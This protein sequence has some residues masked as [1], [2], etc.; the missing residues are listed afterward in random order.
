MDIVSI[1]NNNMLLTENETKIK[2]IQLSHDFP[3]IFII[4]STN[5]KEMYY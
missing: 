1:E 4:Y 3:D 2:T 5:I